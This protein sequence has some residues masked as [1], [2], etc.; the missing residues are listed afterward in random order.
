[1]A[2]AIQSFNKLQLG[3]E[4]SKGTNVAATKVIHGNWNLVEEQDFYRSEYPAG[5]RANVGGAGTIL[6]KGVTIDGETELTAEEILWFLQTGIRGQVTGA[7]QTTDQSDYLYTFTPQLTTG[8][9]TIDTATAEM[10]RSDGS[11]NHYVGEAPYVMTR[12]F[13]ID[14][15]F[16]EIARLRAELFGRA[17]E[18][19]TPTGSLSEYATREALKSNLLS[20]FLDTSWVGLG[21]TQLTGI[22]RSASFECTT[23]FEPNYSMDGRANL[24]FSNHKVGKL[25][26]TLSLVQELDSVGAGLFTKYRA[27][28]VVYVRLLNTGSQI[29]TGDN[30]AVQI[31]GA[32]RF[33]APPELSEDGEQVLVSAE[34]ESVY[35]VTGT[36]TLEF[37]V[38]TEESSL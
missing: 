8:I 28:D 5:V 7:E 21:G 26:A 10:V 27:N 34:L 6:R 35:D 37:A 22:N 3:R 32:Y 36:K 29:G 31:D 4:S 13:G 24:D 15:T 30:R 25:A 1:M 38:T 16:N 33:T 2:T 12:M 18:S 9:P 11:T 14:W 23:G 20:I 17:R 19:D